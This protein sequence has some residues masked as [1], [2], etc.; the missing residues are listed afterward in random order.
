[1]PG[2]TF[3]EEQPYPGLRSRVQEM[4]RTVGGVEMIPPMVNRED[5]TDRD[6]F[7]RRSLEGDFDK[8]GGDFAWN[9]DA[10]ATS[11]HRRY[12]FGCSPP[13]RAAL[14]GATLR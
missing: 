7:W 10:F 12:P 11:A 9:D 14:R 2:V 13:G 8:A 3:A 4:T 6:T 5:G 1:M